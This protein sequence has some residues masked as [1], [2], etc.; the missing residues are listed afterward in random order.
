MDESKWCFEKICIVFTKIPYFKQILLTV[1]VPENYS[2]PK[3][4]AGYK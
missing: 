4:N 1:A 3:K 2:T